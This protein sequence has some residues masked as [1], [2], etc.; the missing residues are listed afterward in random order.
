MRK[1]CENVKYFCNFIIS[2]IAKF[3]N[4]NCNYTC[5][6]IENVL[7]TENVIKP[8]PD[9]HKL[10]HG[11]HVVTLVESTVIIVQLQTFCHC[12][13]TIVISW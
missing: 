4:Y 5:T 2:A 12:K 7:E 6:F 10:G 9:L 11:S 3:C 13:I 1:C 8:I